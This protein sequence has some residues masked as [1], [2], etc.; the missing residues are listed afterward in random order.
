MDERIDSFLTHILE[1]KGVSAASIRDGVRSYLVVYENLVRDTEPDPKN[2]DAAARVWRKLYRQK[3][4]E[5]ITNHT[6]TPLGEFRKLVLSA[7]DSTGA[8][9]TKN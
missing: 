8:P 3:V 4:A 2:R 1:L 7:V 5:E 9:P 6:G